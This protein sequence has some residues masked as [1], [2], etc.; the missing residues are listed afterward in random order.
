ML[1]VICNQI[2]YTL[3][4]FLYSYTKLRTSSVTA[5]IEYSDMWTSNSSGVITTTY[6]NADRSHSVV[7]KLILVEDEWNKY[8]SL[9]VCLSKWNTILCFERRQ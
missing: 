1:I 2:I 4:C 5:K 9:L 8:D 3:S 7:L 6:G